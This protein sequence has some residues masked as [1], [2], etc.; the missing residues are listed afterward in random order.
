MEDRTFEN[1]GRVVQENLIDPGVLP[2]VV[3]PRAMQRDVRRA[4]DRVPEV[5]MRKG[6]PAADAV[7]RLKGR[8]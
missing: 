2:D 8:R 5:P 3:M 1:N 7:E 4:M 6:V